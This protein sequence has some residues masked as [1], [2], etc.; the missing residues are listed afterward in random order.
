MTK[1]DK[2]NELNACIRGEM[3][4]LE[5]LCHEYGG[6]RKDIMGSLNRL[7][8]LK[9]ELKFVEEQQEPEYGKNEQK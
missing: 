9:E 2:I 8:A 7:K 4:I 5:S 3:E 1:K 6:F